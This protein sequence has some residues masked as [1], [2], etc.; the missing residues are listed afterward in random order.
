[1]LL[2]DLFFGHVHFF[3]FMFFIFCSFKVLVSR[4]ITWSNRSVIPADRTEVW[5]NQR[6]GGWKREGPTRVFPWWLCFCDAAQGPEVAHSSVHLPRCVWREPIKR[7]MPRKENQ[8]E[9]RM[10]TESGPQVSYGEVRWGKSNVG[11][12]HKC[13]VRFVPHELLWETW[14]DK[15]CVKGQLN[16]DL[17]ILYFNVWRKTYSR[18]LYFHMHVPQVPKTS[19]WVSKQQ[20]VSL[21]TACLHRVSILFIIFYVIV[22]FFYTHILINM[23]ICCVFLFF[24]KLPHS[25]DVS[26]V[27]L[28]LLFGI[29]VGLQTSPDAQFSYQKGREAWCVS[30]VHSSLA[31]CCPLCTFERLLFQSFVCCGSSV[32]KALPTCLYAGR[33]RRLG[34]PRSCA[35]THCHG[36]FCVVLWDLTVS[37]HRSG[38][39]RTQ[40]ADPHPS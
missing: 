21:N 33:L 8:S 28:L 1:M 3:T 12:S 40:G 18:Q 30:T 4:R 38:V 26:H 11:E 35:V 6:G 25:F 31:L 20:W 34:S 7:G 9:E 2:C 24:F 5:T 17:C 36:S 19:C 22:L 14:S 37:P 29:K 10:E 32:L 23:Y 39:P 13:L 15:W 27:A 16:S